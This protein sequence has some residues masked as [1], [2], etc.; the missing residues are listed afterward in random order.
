MIQP[1]GEVIQKKFSKSFP[2]IRFL[3]SGFGVDFDNFTGREK[4][5]MQYE[6]HI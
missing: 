6:Y 5:I 4:P 1:S 2:T 3:F